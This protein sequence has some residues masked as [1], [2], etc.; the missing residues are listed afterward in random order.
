M[1]KPISIISILIAIALAVQFIPSQGKKTMNT[2]EWLPSESSPKL[3]PMEITDG[4]FIYSDG[5]SINLPARKVI[6]NGWGNPGSIHITGDDL[7][8][9]PV[10]LNVSWFSYTED[11]FYS[12]SYELPH[13]KMLDLFLQGVDS[14][15]TGE[16]IT[17]DNILVGIAPEGEVSVWMSAEAI[18]LEVATYK[19]KS[20]DIDWAKILDNDE[21]S[22]KDYIDIVF[23]ETMDNNQIE[24][25]KDHGVPKGLWG[26]YR[27]QNQWKP[28]IIGSQ[29]IIMWLK[30]FN[31]ENEYFDFVK[32]D[33]TRTHRAVPKKIK[34]NWQNKSGQ[35]YT[36]TI[37][38]DE[39]EIFKAY[40]KLMTGKPEHELTLQLEISEQSH[41]I[42]VFLKDKQFI[43][44]LE[45][46]KIKTYKME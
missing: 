43:L 16:K 2:F 18:T 22:R 7:K 6:H 40:E 28:E 23:E 8:P 33:N 9:V 27:L 34:I 13:D 42:D 10:K 1:A 44:K 46:N 32:T 4:E 14:P 26:K 15:T 11:K 3:Y 20:A 12:G 31:G 45:K 25:L 35:K 37:H 36:A 17:Y 5:S 29:P 30:T 39:E 19:A 38:F 41:S 21:V 24:A